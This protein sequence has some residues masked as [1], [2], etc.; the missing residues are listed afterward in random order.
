MLPQFVA[1]Q[2][3]PGVDG[4]TGWQDGLPHVQPTVMSVFP[5]EPIVANPPSSSSVVHEVPLD[6]VQ[7]P[8]DEGT[9]R[10]PL[11]STKPALH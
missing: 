6:T 3:R 2:V 1:R 7:R 5:H 10:P 8:T 4:Q 11:L 9:Q